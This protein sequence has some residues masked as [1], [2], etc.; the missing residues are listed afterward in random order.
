MVDCT[1]RPEVNVPRESRVRRVASSAMRRG[2]HAAEKMVYTVGDVAYKVGDTS[3]KVV[4]KV[5]DVTHKVG[6]TSVTALHSIGSAVFQCFCTLSY[7]RP[8]R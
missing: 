1:T 7:G 6:D 5:G 8:I 3:A 4:H 2:S